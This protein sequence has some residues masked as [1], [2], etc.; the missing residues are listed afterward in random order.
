MSMS[1]LKSIPC[2]IGNQYNS[3]RHSVVLSLYLLFKM[4]FA[5]VFCIC[6]LPFIDFLAGLQVWNC[7]SLDEIELMI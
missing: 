5:P 2:C 3:L 6:C 4:I 1:I 7:S